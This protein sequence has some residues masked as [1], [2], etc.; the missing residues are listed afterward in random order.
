MLRII[1]LIIMIFC[2]TGCNQPQTENDNNKAAQTGF[3]GEREPVTRAEVAKMLALSR[4]T[5][6]EINNLERTITFKDTDIQKWYDKYINAAYNA[7]FIAGTDEENFS[8]E[9]NLSLKQA[10]V[11][12]KK[13]N[14]SGSFELKFSEV[15][16]DKPISYK[17]WLEA[18]TKASGSSVTECDIFV[19]ATGKQCKELGDKYI[20]CNGGLRGVDGIDFS[21]YAD[22][23]VR[24]T[25]KDNEVLG[26]SRIVD[27]T[28]VLKNAEITETDGSNITVKLNGALREFDVDNSE[29]LYKTGDKID[30]TFDADG[31]YQISQGSA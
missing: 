13:I 17:I 26:I 23:I 21:P 11:L 2:F 30:I 18:F 15:D 25:M 12:V 22:K 16:R 7:Q 6:E 28:P 14:R 5:M 4:Y 1:I 19:Y 10:Q 8:P 3:V 9:E 24:V 20:L 29:N 27:A 31:K